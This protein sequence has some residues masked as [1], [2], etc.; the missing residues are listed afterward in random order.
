MNQATDRTTDSNE[1]SLPDK[2]DPQPPTTIG[3]D[4]DDTHEHP[5][6]R[7]VVII[8][9]ALYIAMFLVSLVRYPFL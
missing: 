7:T 8:M 3:E 9:C 2:S 4:E 6:M 1:E 5:P